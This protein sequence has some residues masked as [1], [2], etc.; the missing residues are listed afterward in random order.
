M[1]LNCGVGEDSWESLGLQ[2]DPTQSILKEISPGI[3]LE[4]M[5]LKLKFQYFGH[6][7]WRVDSLEKSLMFWG[8]EGRRRRGQQRMRWLGGITDSMDMSLSELRELVMDRDAWRAAI[9]GVAKSRTLLSKWTELNW[10]EHSQRLWHDQWRR[11]R[12]FSGNLLVFINPTDVGNFISGSSAFS[13]FSLN[14]WKFTDHALRK[15][16]LGIF[17]QYFTSVCDEC[18]CAGVRAFFVIASLWDWNEN[19]P[20]PVLWPLL[21]FPNLLA[22][23]VQH[24]HSIIF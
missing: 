17:E 14:I 15:P 11:N 22:Y 1:F 3:S 6:L 5:M 24:F 20:F 12:C 13:K 10:T 16:G 9:H 18:N 23:W 21:S 2:V 7:M 4:G 8:I 19:V